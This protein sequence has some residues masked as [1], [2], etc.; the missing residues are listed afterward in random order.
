MK[1]L[2]EMYIRRTKVFGALYSIVPTVVWFAVMMAYVPFR[3][4]YLLRL[5]LALGVG[6][7]VGARANDYGVRMW[8]LKHRSKEGPASVC[9]G[10]LI[11]AAVGTAIVLLPPLTSLIATNHP[12][13]AKAFIICSWLV[14]IAFG[15]L[16]GAVLASIGIKHLDRP[17]E[18]AAAKEGP[19]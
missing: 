11:G 12:E 16:L 7:Y 4:V 14:G 15:A 6:G 8:L 2:C 1:D 10:A 19:A 5:V 18:P 17:T 13:E 9:D 3:T